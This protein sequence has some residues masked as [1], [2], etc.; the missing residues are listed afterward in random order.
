MFKR[1][2][3]YRKAETKVKKVTNSKREIFLKSFYGITRY[4]WD[5]ILEVSQA[6]DAAGIGPKVLKHQ[7]TGK[8]GAI[9]YEKVHVFSEKECDEGILL[10]YKTPEYTKRKMIEAIKI[11]HSLGWAHIDLH[12]GNV[13]YRDSNTLLLLDMDTAIRIK[14]GPVKWMK[15]WME[16]IWDWDWSERSFGECVTHDFE[17]WWVKGEAPDSSE[18]STEGE[19]S[20]EEDE[21]STNDSSDESTKSSDSSSSDSSSS[22]SESST[23]ESTSSSESSS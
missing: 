14:E 6:L 10:P 16:E 7:Y 2:G 13:G 23:L 4:H 5:R 21:S 22:S 18:S 1:I 3:I 19:D 12:N 9:A 11:M 17:D 8:N 20:S 15:K